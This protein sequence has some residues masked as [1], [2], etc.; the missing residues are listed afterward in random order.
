MFLIHGH[1]RAKAPDSTPG[2][3]L[4]SVEMVRI[5]AVHLL[6]VCLLLLAAGSGPGRGLALCAPAGSLGGPVPAGCPK[7]RERHGW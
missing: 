6:G 2:T 5:P 1:T 7:R 4:L 3:F